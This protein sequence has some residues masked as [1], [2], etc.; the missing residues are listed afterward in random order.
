MIYFGKLYLIAHMGWIV[1]MYLGHMP[2]HVEFKSCNYFGTM[3]TIG[4]II[5][6]FVCTV[7]SFAEFCS[8]VMDALCYVLFKYLNFDIGVSL[9][10][11]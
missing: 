5:S 2:T 4:L 1:D 9:S 11:E 6:H 3:H 7:P 8:I 10:P